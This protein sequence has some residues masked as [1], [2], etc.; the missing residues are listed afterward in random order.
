V[1]IGGEPVELIDPFW[2]MAQ[3]GADEATHPVREPLCRLVEDADGWASNFLAPILRSAGYRVVGGDDPEGVRADVQLCLAET[4][5]P[6][7][8]LAADVPLV[9]LRSTVAAAG[10]G[11]DSIYRY[12]RAALLDALRRQVAGGRP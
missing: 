12:D 2:L 8:P 4:G 9:R 6:T 3:Y 7:G 5:A 10:P 11:D 1:L